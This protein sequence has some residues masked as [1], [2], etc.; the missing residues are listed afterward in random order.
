MPGYPTRQTLRIHCKHVC[1]PGCGARASAASGIRKRRSRQV[2]EHLYRTS[3]GGPSEFQRPEIAADHALPL[4][5][6]CDRLTSRAS[7]ARNARRGRAPGADVRTPAFPGRKQAYTR[8]PP[9]LVRV[10]LSGRLG[11][12]Y[13]DARKA[14]VKRGRGRGRFCDERHFGADWAQRV[15]LP[16]AS[17]GRWSQRTSL[18]SA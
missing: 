17:A 11:F 2:H 4:A 6:D 5:S 9:A 15:V 7:D 13:G 10:V 16:G 3:E 8:G 1:A 18:S 14:M 12:G